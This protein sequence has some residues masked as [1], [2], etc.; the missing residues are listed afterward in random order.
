MEGE[1]LADGERLG[2]FEGLTDGEILD[3]GPNKTFQ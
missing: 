3:E 2:L 1:I